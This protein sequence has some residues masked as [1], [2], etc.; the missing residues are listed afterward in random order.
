MAFFQ[1]PARQPALRVPA[2]TLGLLVALIGA[3]IARVMAPAERSGVILADYAFIPAR[4]SKA[5]LAAHGIDPGTLLDRAIPFVSYIFLHANFTHLAVN[6]VWLLP[7]GAI[8]ARRFGALAFFAFF[9]ICGVAGAATHLAF[10]WGSP[11]PVIGASAAVSGMMAAGFRML[12]PVGEF[13]LE[14]LARGERPLAPI[15]S[16]QILMLS[17]MW[18]AIN[19]LA[20]VTGLG[21]GPGVHLIAWQ[22]HIGGYMA[23]LLL[24]GPFDILQSRLRPASNRS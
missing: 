16:S 23:G 8:T 13:G 3:H 18:I 14:V 12:P 7:F 9:L 19:V 1:D 6:C 10:D 11:D 2:A 5:F 21:A 22:A 17:A 4:Y 24:A 20:G 15:L